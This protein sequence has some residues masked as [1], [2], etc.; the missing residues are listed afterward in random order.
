MDME[1]RGY[2]LGSVGKT[3]SALFTDLFGFKPK[4]EKHHK[5]K[6]HLESENPKAFQEAHIK[7]LMM[8][9]VGDFLY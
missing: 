7:N 1:A 8:Q 4:K 2:V 3:V 6:H 5:K 9:N